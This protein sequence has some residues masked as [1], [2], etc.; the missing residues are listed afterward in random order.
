MT[1]RSSLRATA[2]V[3]LLLGA[4]TPSADADPLLGLVRY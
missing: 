1:N 4:V 3:V 2:A